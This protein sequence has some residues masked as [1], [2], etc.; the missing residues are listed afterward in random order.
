M[1]SS[2]IREPDRRPRAVAAAVEGPVLRVSLADGRELSVPLA[3][4][5]WLEAA[6]PD[7]QDDCQLCEDGLSIWWDR[8]EDGLSVPRLLGLPE[9][10]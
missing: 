3:W 7:L 2:A 6:A 4:F 9:Y 10:P 5:P 8:L 1:T